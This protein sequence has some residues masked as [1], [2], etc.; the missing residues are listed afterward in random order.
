MITPNFKKIIKSQQS[1]YTITLRVCNHY[2]DVDMSLLTLALFE[3][4]EGIIFNLK[5]IVSK[6]FTSV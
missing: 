1:I 2:L 3:E 5:N 4:A 6:I